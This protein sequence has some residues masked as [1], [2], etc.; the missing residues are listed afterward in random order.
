MNGHGATPPTRCNRPRGR[1]TWLPVPRIYSVSRTPL[2]PFQVL[3]DWDARADQDEA[4]ARRGLA[5]LRA[6]RSQEEAPW[7]AIAREV[8]ALALQPIG[9]VGC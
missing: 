7:P 6:L 1:R 9:A 3:L 4:E 2:L 8:D 5:E